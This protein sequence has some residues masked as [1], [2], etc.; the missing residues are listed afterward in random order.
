[1]EQIPNILLILIMVLMTLMLIHG[2][3]TRRKKEQLEKLYEDREIDIEEL[4]KEKIF[5]SAEELEKNY[6]EQI[7]KLKEENRKMM[8]EYEEKI[9][10]LTA[11]Y[12]R[13]IANLKE[14]IK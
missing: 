9:E 5:Y 13:E 14:K 8:L 7:T 3:I 11:K 10:I 6:Q 12:K 2:I 4:T 1:M